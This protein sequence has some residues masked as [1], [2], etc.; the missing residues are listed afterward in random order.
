MGT[1]NQVRNKF[2]NTHKRHKTA[3]LRGDGD[4]DSV[5][6][7]NHKLKTFT[8]LNCGEK[9]EFWK[10]DH[11]GDWIYSCTNNFCFKSKDF[12]GSM[13]IKLKKL[14]KQQQMYSRLNYRTY[15]GAYY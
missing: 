8:C 9:M 6:L 4:P 1:W 5:M 13:T 15:D 14:A 3:H 10:E 2:I 11:L 12:A 7:G